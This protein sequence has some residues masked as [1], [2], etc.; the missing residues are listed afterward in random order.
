MLSL[1]PLGFAAPLALAGLIALPVIWWLLRVTPPAP[2]RVRFPALRLLRG[3]KD[4]DETPAKTPWWLLALRLAAA[5]LLILA[6]AEPVANPSR[7]DTGSGPLLLVVD[8]GWAA[9]PGWA[10]RQATLD[11]LLANARRTGRDVTL[12]TTTPRAV[13]AGLDIQTA[14]DATATANAL[15]PRAL[16]PDYAAATA[17]LTD[18]ALPDQGDWQVVWLSDGLTGP[19]VDGFTEALTR[20]GPVTL[21]APQPGNTALAIVP[22]SQ[23]GQTLQVVLRRADDEGTRLGKVAAIGQ[24]ERRLAEAEFT[25]A[26][27]TTETTVALDMPLELRNAV[28][29]IEILGEASAGAVALLDDRWQR[30]TVGLVSGTSAEDAQPLLSD[31]YYLRRAVGPFAEIRE[32]RAGNDVSEIE[33]LLDR[34]L[35]LL[36]TADVGQLVGDDADRV[37]QWVDEGG[38]L[39]RFAGSRL[40]AQTDDLMPV[41]LRGGGRALGGAL[42]WATPQGLAPFDETSPFAGL[43]I[44]D[45]VEVHRQVLADPT[46]DLSDRIWARLTDGTPLVTAARRGE[47]WIVLFHV[48]ADTDWSSLPISGLYVE[49]LRR[50]VDLSRGTGGSDQDTE[51]LLAPYRAL[52]GRGR[53]VAPP[54]LAKPIA[55]QAIA[56]TTP[57]PAHPA[58]LYGTPD[59]FR[60]LNVIDAT[61][62]LA[63]LDTGFA[64]ET[65]AY[66]GSSETA[67]K[68]VLLMLALLLL[69]ADGIIALFL[70]GRLRLPREL[71][72][73]IRLNR[74]TAALLALALVTPALS[75][76]AHAQSDAAD[77]IALLATL[78]T[79]LAYVKTG[80]DRIDDLSRAGLSGLSQILR[81]R[82]AIEP[83]DPLGVDVERDELAFYPLL[84]WPVL[85]SQPQL[86]PEALAR[87]DNYMKRGGTIL[88]DT[89]DHQRIEAIGA[90]PG[91]EALR[92]LLGNLDVPPLEPVSEGHVLTKAFYLLQTFPGRWA[93]GDL[94]VQAQGDAGETPGTLNQDGVTPL[95][96][97]ANDYA[98]AWAVD[99][100]GLPMAKPVPGGERQREMARRFGVNLV[101]YAL[102]GNYKA[103]QVHVPALLERLGQ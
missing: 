14:E 25:F 32:A 98:A 47:G 78:D 58:G 82:T 19:A 81:S 41:P 38:T 22:P 24:A 102:T 26:D 3:L 53:L 31:L 29:R 103:D 51:R 79:R 70:S 13:A 92:R 11:G 84:Y 100:R 57:S 35:S 20:H 95:L 48:S 64:A 16:A 15:S 52:D 69:L 56:E 91:N 62:S 74:G 97:G 101:M 28:T 44:P 86:S 54:A 85:P 88:F 60:A 40:A 55:L 36:I 75:D 93:G 10:G 83:A 27:G 67:L 1:G 72:A 43:D 42:T 77:E 12:L 37:G 7:Q 4:E 80:D 9:A 18:A 66:A 34:P 17:R 73:R 49:M 5:T 99:A 61:T 63:P 46:A 94:W 87:V 68:P 33:S 45:D 96:I 39:I 59:G 90:S 21:V 50:I 2:N 8:D 76:K 71:A 30:R 6:F 65:D 89:M 23:L